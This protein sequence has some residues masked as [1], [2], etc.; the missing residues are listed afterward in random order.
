MKH[1]YVA[2]A[3]ASMSTILAC[4]GPSAPGD[5]SIATSE[6]PIVGGS[7]A[8]QYPEAAYLNIDF[9]A[10]GGYICS[11]ALIAPRVVL[12]AGHCVDGHKSWEVHVGPETRQSV[13]AATFDWNEKGATTVNPDHHDVGLVFLDKPIAL[14]A[15]P[16]LAS[17][18]LPNGSKVTNVGRIKS[19]VATNSLYAADSVVTA[20]ASI[21][22][23]YAYASSAI[24]QPGDS[25]GPDFASGTHNIVAVNSG[26]GGNVEVLA[27]VDLVREW[28]VQ[29]VASHGGPGASS[30]AGAPP[31]DGGDAASPPP[32]PPPPPPPST[33]P[34][35]VE[36][37]NTW[38]TASTLAVG[39][40]CGT[41]TAGDVDWSSVSAAAGPVTVTL[42]GDGDA[43]MGVGQAAGSACT[44]SITGLRSFS[45]AAKSTQRYCVVVQSRTGTAQSYTLAR[46]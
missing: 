39:R 1:W 30:D 38:A 41:L 2:C 8:K 20:G 24:I 13:S 45:V 32:P 7:L 14:A 19:G 29:Q 43:V 42:G 4:S 25:G 23:P 46:N 44:P 21:G 9:T 36:S 31:G 17:S 40:S 28:I 5:E 12:T 34:A 33:C 15:Y 26:V 27:R 3:L 10:S 18:A 35:D 37:N 22:Y 6:D 16:T 11:A